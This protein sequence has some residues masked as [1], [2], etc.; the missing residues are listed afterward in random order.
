MVVNGKTWPKL[1]VEARKYRLRILNGSDSRF[2][3]PRGAHGARDRA[4]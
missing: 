2:L 3:I 4:G 1:T